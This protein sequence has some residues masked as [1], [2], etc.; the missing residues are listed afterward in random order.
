MSVATAL[1]AEHAHPA[2]WAKAT[3][4][5]AFETRKVGLN[6]LGGETGSVVPQI[7]QTCMMVNIAHLDRRPGARGWTNARGG[8]GTKTPGRIMREAQSTSSTIVPSGVMYNFGEG[9][10]ALRMTR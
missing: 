4:E 3:G 7:N 6:E 2:C 9:S 1:M 5:T 10:E 8:P